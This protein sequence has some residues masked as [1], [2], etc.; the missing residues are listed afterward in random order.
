MKLTFQKRSGYPF[1]LVEEVHK[2]GKVIGLLEQQKQHAYK[3]YIGTG[4]D[5]RYL[6]L[7]LTKTAAVLAILLAAHE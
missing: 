1:N 3:A 6:S 4:F 2:D 5:C 7:Y